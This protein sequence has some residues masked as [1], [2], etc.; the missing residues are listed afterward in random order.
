MFL[1]IFLHR[2]L[3]FADVD[4]EDDESLGREFLVDVVE[5]ALFAFA[6]G[7]PGRPELE[8]DDFAFD[9]GVAEGLSVD[10]LGVEVRCGLA[11]VVAFVWRSGGGEGGD[12]EERDAEQQTARAVARGEHVA[13]LE[14]GRSASAI[15]W[16]PNEY[17][18]TIRPGGA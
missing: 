18:R 16:S 11:F 7:A 13:S 5:Q 6:D 14:S 2:L 10:S 17:A 15:S 4:G 8:E 3:A 1:Q 9:G 12:D